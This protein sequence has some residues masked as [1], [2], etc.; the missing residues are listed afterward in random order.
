MSKPVRLLLQAARAALGSLPRGLLPPTAKAL[1]AGATLGLVAALLP[2][3]IQAGSPPGPGTVP[4]GCAAEGAVTAPADVDM[5]QVLR[6]LYALEDSR[7]A[8]L[9]PAENRALN[10]K[11]A[12]L[13]DLST[14][15]S[16]LEQF[17]TML[18]HIAQH[19]AARGDR[20]A[21]DPSS[22][23]TLL[24][25][26]K[27]FS[28]PEFPRRITGIELTRR[29]PARPR[30]RVT[31]DA[32]EV[33]L[34]LNQ[35]KGFG[36]VREGMCQHARELV[37]YGEFSFTLVMKDGGLE[38]QDFD[39]VDL[40][41]NFGSRGVVDVDVNYVSIRSVAFMRGSALG[42]VKAKV[43]RREFEVNEHSFLLALVTR[44]VTDNSIQPIDW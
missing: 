4:G 3:A 27:V 29:D 31:F 18:F 26:S 16:K 24:L 23:R 28:Y 7:D 8:R 25:S 21:V 2:A 15:K 36:V 40:F 44:F 12:K 9:F 43:S 37:F 19:A 10:A 6:D 30:Y 1:R 38:V 13:F 20:F 32:S 5:A 33:R 14:P 41:G 17:Y 22:V 34:P 42:L 39:K 35:G 11:M